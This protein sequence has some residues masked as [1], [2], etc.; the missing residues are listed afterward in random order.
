[1]IHRLTIAV[2]LD[3]TISLPSE[4]RISENYREYYSRLLPNLF[5]VAELRQIKKMG[6]IIV[7]YTARPFEDFFFTQTWL[8]KYKVPHDAL[9]MGKLR[10]DLY[11]DSASVRLDDDPIAAIKDLVVRLKAKSKSHW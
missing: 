8:K 10:A 6:H 3:E 11:I 4:K 9:Q 7:V 1:M 2:D 5:F